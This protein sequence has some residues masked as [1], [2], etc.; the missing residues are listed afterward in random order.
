MVTL[1]LT[2]VLSRLWIPM[3]GLAC[4]YC[5]PLSPSHIPTRK[6]NHRD[7]DCVF[8]GKSATDSGMKSATDSDLIWANPI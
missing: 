3:I 5:S 1:A 6:S 7:H 4:T 8:R 2:P